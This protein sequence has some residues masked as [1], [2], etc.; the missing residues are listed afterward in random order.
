MKQVK[1]K[2]NYKVKRYGSV[3]HESLAHYSKSQSWLCQNGALHWQPDLLGGTTAAESGGA[4]ERTEQS[5]GG[6]EEQG[7]GTMAAGTGGSSWT[8]ITSCTSGGTVGFS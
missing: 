5:G 2:N 8:G 6:A 4:P 3:R 7:G 1:Q